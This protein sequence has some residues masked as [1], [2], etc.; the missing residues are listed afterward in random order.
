MQPITLHNYNGYCGIYANLWQPKTSGV[1]APVRRWKKS[2]GANFCRVCDKH[3]NL[4]M[5]LFLSD[6]NSR[7]SLNLNILCS[8]HSFTP[9]IIATRPIDK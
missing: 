8:Q 6:E 9:S 2:Q 5:K 1:R 4:V 3:E 7:S